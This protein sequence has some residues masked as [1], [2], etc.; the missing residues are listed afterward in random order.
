M[1]PFFCIPAMIYYQI[2]SL[3]NNEL[4]QINQ[5]T[6][7][8]KLKTNPKKSQAC[9]IDYKLHL[10]YDYYFELK[11]CDHTI[12]ISDEIKYLRV[13]LDDKLNF[14]CHIKFLEAK[15]SRNV[16]ILFKLKKNLAYFSLSNVVFC[17]DTSFPFLRCNIVGS[18]QKIVFY[19]ITFF[20]K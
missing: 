19:K 2:K 15:L 9:I 13:E 11:Y 16:G 10:S 7:A 6:N 5:W 8:N 1:I 4:R 20:T 12:Q 14:L 3:C 18:L 17:F